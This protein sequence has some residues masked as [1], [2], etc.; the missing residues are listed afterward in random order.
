MLIS[1]TG[2]F[3]TSSNDDPKDPKDPIINDGK[4]DT[5]T[6]HSDPSQ[7]P[8]DV[9]PTVNVSSSGI[10][11][12]FNLLI[13]RIQ[14][15]E[16]VETPSQ[17]YAIDFA[18]LKRGFGT[19]V[20]KSSNDVKANIGFITA[21]V[22]SV[23]SDPEIQKVVD[24]LEKFID[25]FDEYY[26]YPDEP[27]TEG[28]ATEVILSKKR[29]LSKKAVLSEG[30]LSKTYSKHGI[31]SAGE[32]LLASSPKVIM[33]QTSQRPSFPRFLTA[34]YIQN[35]IENSIVSRLNEIISS[36][37]RLRDL[38]T[39]SLPVTIDGE[40][41]EID[42]G[43]I[44]VLESA[45]R[46]ARA[47]FSLM[48][49]YN[50][51]IL[52]PNGTNDMQ[53]INTYLDAI[54]NGETNSSLTYKVS[55][56]SLFKIYYSDQS[57]MIAP[58][59]D[60]YTYNYNRPD[61]LSVRRQFHSAVYS[62]LKE[63]PIL[64]KSA[65]SSIKSEADNQDDDVFPAADIFDMTSEMS[66]LSAEMLDEGVSPGL[67]AKFQTPEAFMDFVSLLLTQPYTFNETIDGKA[68]SITVDISKIFTN[69]ANSLKDY[70]PKYKI[71]TGNE[72]YV[73]YNVYSSVSEGF[74]YS[75]IYIYEN[76]G[77]DTVILNIPANL[78]KSRTPPQYQGGATVIQLTKPYNYSVYVDSIR[79][80]MPVLYVDDNGKALNYMSL[81][82]KDEITKEDIN[83]CFPYFNDYTMRG[84][85]P[86]M[87]TRQKWIDL[88]SVF[89]E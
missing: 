44:L 12:M 86:E 31:L 68:F 65:L 46:A 22:L 26:A 35:I 67:A 11:S 2:C 58:V 56:D 38:A 57:A 41:Y 10:D 34:S 79:T 15:L 21:S 72:R 9:D 16:N 47:A 3:P 48:L 19:A 24:S 64:L 74:E 53:W 8:Q 36:T 61:F 75:S 77:Y 63:I 73:S 30:L 43:D 7:L 62:D 54:Q 4:Q 32:V 82:G 71:P 27:I 18:S 49:I 5:T 28:T 60:V 33:A 66:D 37:Q 29:A 85:F 52:S 59:I 80:M 1:L 45:A 50:Y 40:T 13:Q 17:V 83:A 78:I 81:L 70:W 23:N 55:G 25:D 84:I 88:V 14:L 69:P 89:A 6:I 20:S 87:A 39:V 42:K 51:D 76:E